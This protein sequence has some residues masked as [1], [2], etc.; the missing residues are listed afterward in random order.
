[1]TSISMGCP[2]LNGKKKKQNTHLEGT[3]MLSMA[4]DTVN[5]PVLDGHPHRF[6]HQHQRLEARDLKEGCPAYSQPC[7]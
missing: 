6:P 7:A 1:M 4:K 5:I 2:L 3:E